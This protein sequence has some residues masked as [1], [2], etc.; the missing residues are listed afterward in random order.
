MMNRLIPVVLASARLTVRSSVRDQRALINHYCPE[1]H[2]ERLKCSGLTL[3]RLDMDHSSST[4]EPA[5]K[6]IKKVRA[7]LTPPAGL[8]PPDEFLEVFAGEAE[9]ACDDGEA[10]DPGRPSLR[11]LSRFEYANS[12]RDLP[13]S[14]IH[15]AEFLPVGDS[16]PGRTFPGSEGN[17]C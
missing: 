3:T 8:Q 7:G 16:S 11:H 12:V 15:S 9:S 13:G 14:E 2:N 10:S 17:L 6:V 4:P 5:K 1:S